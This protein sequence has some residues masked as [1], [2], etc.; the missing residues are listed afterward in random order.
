MTKQADLT[1]PLG[2]MGGPCKVVER[3]EDGVR[4]PAL[5]EDLAEKVE[6]GQKLTNPE[7]SKVYQMEANRG[8]GLIERIRITPH[9]QYRMDQ[10]AITVGDLRSF[11]MDFT[12]KLNDWKS[13]KAW[14]YGHYTS[15]LSSGQLVEWVDKRLG[16][17][18]VVFEITGRGEATIVTTYWKGEPDPRP[19]TCGT[20]PNHLHTA[21]DVEDYSGIRT[22]V[23]NPHPNESDTDKPEGG[24]GK[25][26]TRGLP[27]PPWSRS[28]SDLGPAIYNTPGES[29]SD[30][31][32]TVHKDK[33]R[34][35]GTPGEDSPPANPPARIGPT[36]RPGMTAEDQFLGE[37]DPALIAEIIRLA[38]MYPPA[39]PT[40][41]SRHHKQRGQAYRYFH[42][43][44][45]RMRGRIKQRQKRRY[46]RLRV[47][48][49]FKRDRQRRKETPERFKTKPGGGA[50]STAERSRDYRQKKKA[51]EELQP[52]PFYFYTKEDWGYILDVSPMGKVHYEMGGRRYTEDLDTFFD[53]VVVDEDRLDDLEAYMDD[54]FEYDPGDIDEDD[55]EDDDTVFDA[56]L[57]SPADLSKLGGLVLADFFREMRPPDM[58]KDTWY[59][60]ADNHDEW[61][62][63]DRKHLEDISEWSGKNEGNPGSRV[64]P[65]GAGHVEKEA[66]LIQDIRQGC[67]PDL[68][69][70][71]RGLKVV[72]K[73]VD[74]AN[75]MWLFDV[76]GSKEPYRVR[77]QAVRQ[78]NVR[79]LAK[80]HVRVSC[81]CPFW[82]W[83]GPE[84]HAQQGDYLYGRPVGTASAPL[85][86]DP[87]GKHRACKHVLATLDFVTDRKWDVPE[88]RS[89]QAGLRYLAD[90]LDQGEVQVQPLD[91]IERLA[92]RYLAT[93]EVQ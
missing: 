86:K 4:T 49:R 60:R 81:S 14:E 88:L 9:A 31:S 10:R 64:L 75:A 80:T 44:Y 78:G 77:L 65:S 73:R 82:Q 42:K 67:A 54:V 8:G 38:G 2:W 6:H 72:L 62:R 48:P 92:L 30:S 66:A 17:L 41:T 33:V 28:K 51:I 15:L 74:A 61:A 52:V 29:G 7:A 24:D 20:H 71:A 50:F 22:L 23:K 76:Q 57:Q 37:E 11:F 93:R 69:S 5:R 59:D 83:Q 90:T 13:Q 40:S 47:D 53:E 39:Y 79:S 58:D 27:G 18:Q 89:K 21:K 91:I 68:L 26:P 19:Q 70:K 36:R 84:Y 85:E 1:P 35:K 3:I 46:K 55:P 56:W 16:D 43:R 87:Q 34:T 25:Y 63:R 45:Q 12:K 32:G